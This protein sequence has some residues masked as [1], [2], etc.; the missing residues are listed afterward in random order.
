MDVSFVTS[1]FFLAL[2][3]EGTVEYLVAQ[4]LSDYLPDFKVVV[5]YIAAVI[6]IG[7]AFG[8]QVNLPA[9][10]GLTGPDWVGYLVTGII[11]GRGSNYLND[12]IDRVRQHGG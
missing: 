8:F 5:R 3:I 9:L 6:G 4:V 12:L 7:V 10:I 11:I 1:L 2:F